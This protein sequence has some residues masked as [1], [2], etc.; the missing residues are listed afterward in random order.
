MKKFKLIF[1]FL[2]ALMVKESIAQTEPSLSIPLEE[3]KNIKLVLKD[4]FSG[5]EIENYALAKEHYK[6]FVT[7]MN[8]MKAAPKLRMMV[9][10]YKYVIEYTDGR[11]IVII[12]NGKGVADTPVGNFMAAENLIYKYWP[13]TKETF[14]KPKN[15]SNSG[16][17][18]GF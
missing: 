13:I 12:T 2:I 9:S 5:S 1:L 14:C 6:G 10:C 11:K 3:I 7:D 18:F 15:S 17:G 8:A 16:G 4:E